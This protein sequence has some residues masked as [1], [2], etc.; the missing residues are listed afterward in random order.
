MF[1]LFK[2]KRPQQETNPAVVVG[3]IL[4]PLG[5]E[6]LPYGVGVVIASSMSGYSMHE[7]VSLIAITTLAREVKEA[8]GDIVRLMGLTVYGTALAKRLAVFKDQGL[9]HPTQWQVDAN[10]LLGVCHVNAEQMG[11]VDKVLSDPVAGKEPLAKVTINYAPEMPA[12]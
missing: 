9:I 8:D 6:L 4:R 11:W 5:F 7:T 3:E 10:A 12:S 1:G 2:K